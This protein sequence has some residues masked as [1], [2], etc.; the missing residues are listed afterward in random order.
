MAETIPS[1]INT[2]RKAV[3]RWD[4]LDMYHRRK[5]SGCTRLFQK[6]DPDIMYSSILIC[7]GHILVG[8]VECEPA[9]NMCCIFRSVDPSPDGAVVTYLA[10]RIADAR[11]CSLGSCPACLFNDR[12]DRSG[13]SISHWCDT[14]ARA[15]VPSLFNGFQVLCVT[16]AY[17]AACLFILHCHRLPTM[18]ETNALR[19]IVPKLILGWYFDVVFYWKF[20]G[21]VAAVACNTG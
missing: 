14:L 8:I 12:V 17:R 4:D 2:E 9:N 21:Y 5:E 11:R 19:W 15:V 18:E 1:C 3:S 16:C 13:F 10:C 20:D 7:S 6:D